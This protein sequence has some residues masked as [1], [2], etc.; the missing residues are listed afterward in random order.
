M[1]ALV[2]VLLLL[3]L[4]FGQESDKEAHAAA[5]QTVDRF[6]DSWNHY[7]GAAYGV[8]YWPD[9]ELVDPTGHIV[10]GRGAIAKEHVDLW[11]SIFK[12]SHMEAKLRRVRRLDA[13]HI[14]ADFDTELSH[15]QSPPPGAPANGTIR[16]HLKHIL[17]KRKGEW[18]VIAAQ[19]TFIAK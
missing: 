8:N 12:G 5:Q 15:I 6:V 18:K 1:K 9:A 13:N 10:T 14:I 11:A 19:N 16:T 17:E 4:G 3:P 7:D 2:L